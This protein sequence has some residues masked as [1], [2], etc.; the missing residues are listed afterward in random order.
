MKKVTFDLTKSTSHEALSTEEYDRHPIDSLIFRKITNTIS[1]EEWR[2]ELQEL[3]V[4]RSKE[5]LV[6]KSSLH[7]T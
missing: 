6:H 4:F 1:H 2:K 3:H 5:M 7:P